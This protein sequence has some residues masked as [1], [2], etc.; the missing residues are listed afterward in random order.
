MPSATD[1]HYARLI[2]EGAG[3]TR[4]FCSLPVELRRKLATVAAILRVSLRQH[5]PRS[6]M[7]MAH[8][9]HAAHTI[10]CMRAQRMRR[11]DCRD[12]LNETSEQ[13]RILT[14]AGF[15]LYRAWKAEAAND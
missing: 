3:S 6:G 13:R 7:Q 14:R 8:R 5:P 10:Y 4:D 2:L 11:A 15:A 1:T 9:L 12:W